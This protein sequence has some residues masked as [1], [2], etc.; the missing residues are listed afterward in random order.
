MTSSNM[1]SH[2][3]CDMLVSKSGDFAL[4]FFSTS[5]SSASLYLGTWYHNIPGRTVV[6]TANRDNPIAATSSPK[7]AITNSS[8]LVMSDCQGPIIWMTTSTPW[9]INEEQHHRHGSFCSAARHG[10]LCPPVFRW[11]NHMAEF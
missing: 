11:H 10:E 6:W 2:S 4:G 5:S 1:Q 8:G 7:L 9:E 3:S